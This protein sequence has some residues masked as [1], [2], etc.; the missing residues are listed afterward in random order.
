M[1]EIGYTGGP[2]G[3][4]AAAMKSTLDKYEA[5]RMANIEQQNKLEQIRLTGQ[6]DK[7]WLFDTQ[8]NYSPAMAAEAETPQLFT[9][10]EPGSGKTMYGTKKRNQSTGQMQYSDFSPLTP[11]SATDEMINLK[12]A[13]ILEKMKQRAASGSV[14]P[15]EL[16]A[17]DDL[18]AKIEALVQA[19]EA[20]KVPA[21]R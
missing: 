17:D 16:S 11:M 4:V 10:T 15:P 19:N 12:L 5:S 3:N 9:T 13:P 7:P 18:I 2:G 14:L 8:G 20:R 1:Y 6:M 21:M